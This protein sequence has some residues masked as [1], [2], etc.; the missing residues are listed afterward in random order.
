MKVP[1]MEAEFF[2]ADRGTDMT[3]LTVT[4]SYFSKAP[5]NYNGSNYNDSKESSYRYVIYI[6]S[7]EI[8]IVAALIVY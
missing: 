6:H 4:Y 7:N 1:P 5:K 2:Y 3:K 8:C